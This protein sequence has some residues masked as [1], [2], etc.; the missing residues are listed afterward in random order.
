M[1]ILFLDISRNK[2]KH[3]GDLITLI[4]ITTNTWENKSRCD[5]V[6]VHL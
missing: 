6:Y 5:S 1:Y 4:R 3:L 2:Y